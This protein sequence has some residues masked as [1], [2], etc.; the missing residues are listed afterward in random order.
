MKKYKIVKKKQKQKDLMLAILYS[1]GLTQDD[2]IEELSTW[3]KKQEIYNAKN[4]ILLFF[5]T[6]TC[7]LPKYLIFI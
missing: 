7:L 2:G 4:N 6:F 5:A 1:H 3:G